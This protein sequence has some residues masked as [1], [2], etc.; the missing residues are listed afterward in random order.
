MD[1]GGNSGN[2]QATKP[3][4][5]LAKLLDNALL[6]FGKNVPGS[7]NEQT[8]S[9][10]AASDSDGNVDSA[11]PKPTTESKQP[12][13][14][15]DPELAQQ[16]A[17]QFSHMMKQLVEVQKGYIVTEQSN[18]GTSE[19]PKQLTA[20]TNASAKAADGQPSEGE[21]PA[22][23]EDAEFAQA[24]MESLN[25][26]AEKASRIGEAPNETEFWSAMSE[27]HNDQSYQQEFLPF[28]EG[29]MSSLLSKEMLHPSLKEICEKYPKWIED[30]KEKVTA[31]DRERY[32]KQLKV[33]IQS[34][35]GVTIF[36]FFHFQIMQEVC[37]LYEE[38]KEND[39]DEVKQQR[40]Q[41]IVILLQQMQALGH[42]PDDLIGDMP[43]G[44][45]IDPQTGLP[46][47][48]DPNEAST[49]CSLM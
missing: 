25:R 33:R 1:E 2:Q 47:V 22:T 13:L 19:A 20:D 18:A 5:E 24:L 8:A 11:Q 44:W 6:D 37:L 14:Q 43:P 12:S 49:S 7:T 10:A 39:V 34:T 21:A 9:G 23:V 29:F 46:A 26:M 16:A 38:E 40:F 36:L 41:K 27:L 42:P 32:E 30:N 3:D 17:I 48:S 35:Y 45:N 28:M 4:E 31:E 15:F